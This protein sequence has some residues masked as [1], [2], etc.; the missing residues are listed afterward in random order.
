M[1]GKELLWLL[2][3]V[4]AIL[5]F[6][7]AKEMFS[8]WIKVGAPGIIAGCVA[9]L[10]FV[11]MGN[12]DEG[13]VNAL[14]LPYAALGLALIFAAILS[15]LLRV[16]GPWWRSRQARPTAT[17]P[18]NPSPATGSSQSQGQSR[19]PHPTPASGATGPAPGKPSAGWQGYRRPLP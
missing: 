13:T 6:R 17:P 3:A 18:S 19:I 12:L 2:A 15:L 7:V 14:L 1:H 11:G 9:L 10:V 4:G 5:V 16:L 8:T